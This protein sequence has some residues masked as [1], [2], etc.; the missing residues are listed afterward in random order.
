MHDTA[1]KANTDLQ[2]KSICR[3]QVFPVPRAGFSL[4]KLPWLTRVS[5]ASRKQMGHAAELTVTDPGEKRNAWLS[6]VGVDQDG[7]P[8]RLRNIPRL[9]LPK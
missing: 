6:S 9:T 8:H 3:M 5:P 1:S 7:Q 2:E 4:R